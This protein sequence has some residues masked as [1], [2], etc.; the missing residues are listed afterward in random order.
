MKVIVPP[1]QL[2]KTD[3]RLKVPG[4][5]THTQPANRNGAQS[6]P[7]PNLPYDPRDGKQLSTVTL[8]ILHQ[9]SGRDPCS[10]TSPAIGNQPDRDRQA[11][12]AQASLPIG[13]NS[14]YVCLE[15]L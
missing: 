9:L 2:S 10:L 15:A 6:S 7:V 12:Q 1:Y 14:L 3:G 13:N 11:G 4:D 8:G 5:G